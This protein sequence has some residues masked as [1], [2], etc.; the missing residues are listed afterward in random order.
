MPPKTI[1]ILDVI[2]PTI[3]A[4]PNVNVLDTQFII[5]VNVT[6]ST[7]SNAKK[8]GLSAK[9]FYTHPDISTLFTNGSPESKIPPVEKS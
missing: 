1:A 6:N 8:A 5:N 4:F 2:F 7:K 3:P 9:Y